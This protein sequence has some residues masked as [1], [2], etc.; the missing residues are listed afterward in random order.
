MLW[1]SGKSNQPQVEL[2]GMSLIQDIF[3]HLIK[4]YETENPDVFEKSLGYLNDEFPKKSI[5]ELF[6]LYVTEFPNIEI[7]NKYVSPKTFI[8]NNARVKDEN[9]K[10]VQELEMFISTTPIL[11]SVNM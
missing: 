9:I 6:I 4:K 3:Q 11:H 10:I 8:R 7:F 1:N 2:Y 5:E